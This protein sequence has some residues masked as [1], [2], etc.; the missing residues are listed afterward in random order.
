MNNKLKNYRAITMFDFITNYLGI[1]D[2]DVLDKI[3]H[4]DITELNIKGIKRIPNQIVSD[5]DIRTGR[6]ILVK[7][8]GFK[9]KGKMVCAYMRPDLV[10]LEEN[11]V[12]KLDEMIINSL[13][14]DDKKVLK[15]KKR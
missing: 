6:V 4:Y 8:S 14:K 3:N 11:N 5:E 13:Y 1:N 12:S 15:R 7:S 9:H 10:L 2:C